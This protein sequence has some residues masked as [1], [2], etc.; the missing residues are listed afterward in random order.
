MSN[1]LDRPQPSHA[2]FAALKLRSGTWLKLQ[3]L[4][5]KS[6]ACEVEFAA[7]LHGKSI[8]VGLTIVMMEQRVVRAGNRYLVQGFNGQAEF[9]FTSA[10][11]QVTDSPFVHALLTYPESVE[12]RPVRNEMRAKVSFPASVSA[13]KGK[14]ACTMQDLSVAGAMVE[15]ATHWGGVGDQVEIAFATQFENRNVDVSVPALVRH[16]TKHEKNGSYG[17]GLEF[18]D[19]GQNQKLVLY[20]LLFTLSQE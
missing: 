11:L 7:A 18:G 5:D 6:R 12:L 15:S 13:A 10:V 20:Y 2:N 4:A 16:I 3:D 17:Y 1:E 19:I 14:F 9:T 8:F